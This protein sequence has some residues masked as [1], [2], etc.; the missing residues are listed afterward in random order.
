MDALQLFLGNIWFFLIG[1]MLVLYV[2][3]DG[4]DL[5]VGILSLFAGDE[6]SRGTMMASLGSVWDANETWLVVLGGALFGAFPLVYGIA[7]HA[8]YLPVMVMIFGLIFRGV[9]F[10]FHDHARRKSPWGV[11]FGAGSLVAAI[12]QG[13][14]LGAVIGGL[15]IEGNRFTGGLWDWLQPFP[16][17]T[18]IGVTCGYALLGATFLIIKTREEIQQRSYRRARFSAWAML[19][20]AAAVTIWTPLLHD[21]IANKW[22]SLPAFF[23]IAPL[24]LG[25]LLAFLMLMRSLHKGHDHAP[26]VYSLIVFLC[27]FAGLAVSLYP[28]LLPPA[29]TIADAAASPK[30]QV[31]MLTGI[32]MLLP[33][34]LIYNGYQYF[35]FRGKV[36]RHGYHDDRSAEQHE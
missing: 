31:F 24:P 4:F 6:D 12:C 5:G 16:L 27:S 22:F 14:I 19:G 25:A 18:A 10:E 9:A 34:M 30:T 32:G 2:L 15:P 29:V 7:L 35:V 23:F 33:I 28:Y 17:L 1:L 20:A 36:S 3:L 11:A 13:L 26:F 21:H 8:L